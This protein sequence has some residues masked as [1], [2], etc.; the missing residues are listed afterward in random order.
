[1]GITEEQHQH[2]LLYQPVFLL[3]YFFVKKTKPENPE[4]FDNVEAA[5]I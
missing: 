4:V 2:V 1:M 3:L 5:F